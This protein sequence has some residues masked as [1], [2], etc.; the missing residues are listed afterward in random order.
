MNDE[1]SPKWPDD[2]PNFDP[3][4]APRKNKPSFVRS[5]LIGLGALSAAALLV[6]VIAFGLLIG[7]CGLQR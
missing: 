1:S 2:F 5:C 6:L 3:H 4:D 7:F